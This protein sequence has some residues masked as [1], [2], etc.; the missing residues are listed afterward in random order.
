M[1]KAKIVEAPPVGFNWADATQDQLVAAFK[2]LYSTINP[3]FINEDGMRQMVVSKAKGKTPQEVSAISAERVANKRKR[4]PEEI[5][6]LSYEEICDVLRRLNVRIDISERFP[7]GSPIEWKAYRMLEQKL[8]I[9]GCTLDEAKV[10]QPKASDAG[11]WRV[12][13]GVCDL[14]DFSIPFGVTPEVAQ[15]VTNLIGLDPTNSRFG[16][17]KTKKA[18]IL[19]L[20]P[21]IMGEKLTTKE[22]VISVSL[23]ESY[24]L[25]EEALAPKNPR[26]PHKSKK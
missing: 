20:V 9:K 25:P 23:P 5:L 18:Q 3:A 15:L 10:M 14:N 4:L 13:D 6:A 17:A 7:Q 8:K 24:S 19:V 26:G 2:I 22:M 1:A 16:R 21:G 11:Q 12:L